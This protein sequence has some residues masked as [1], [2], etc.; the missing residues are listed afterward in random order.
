MNLVGSD[1]SATAMVM[2]GGGNP[3]GGTKLAYPLKCIIV[4]EGVA[5]GGGAIPWKTGP[6]QPGGIPSEFCGGQS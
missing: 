4:P 3:D 6:F 5:A 2:F 1:L